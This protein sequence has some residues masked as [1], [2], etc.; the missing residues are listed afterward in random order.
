MN[1][2]RVLEYTYMRRHPL[3]RIASDNIDLLAKKDT[4]GHTPIIE[5]AMGTKGN[6][7]HANG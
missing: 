1:H 3:P 7:Q 4:G 6:N 5:H 2:A